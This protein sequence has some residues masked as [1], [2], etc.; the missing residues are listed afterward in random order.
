MNNQA[1]V[2]SMGV[3]T[4]LLSLKS[5]DHFWSIFHIS[6]IHLGPVVKL[7]ITRWLEALEDQPCSIT[8]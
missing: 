4:I 6:H 1:I 2:Y 3:L 5:Y 8:C 7:R